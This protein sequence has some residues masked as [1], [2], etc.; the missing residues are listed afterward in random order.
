MSQPLWKIPCFGGIGNVCAIRSSGGRRLATFMSLVCGR[1]RQCN[2][3]AGHGA[4]P[5]ESVHPGATS[6][7]CV[8]MGDVDARAGSNHARRPQPTPSYRQ[9]SQQAAPWRQMPHSSSETAAAAVTWRSCLPTSAL[10]TLNCALRI[11]WQ[12]T[13]ARRASCDHPQSDNLI[14]RGDRPAQTVSADHLPRLNRK[15]I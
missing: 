10:A 15:T 3:T 6:S 14:G 5:A 4:C 2:K 8:T 13:I 12:P 11:S 9:R 1:Y 7:A